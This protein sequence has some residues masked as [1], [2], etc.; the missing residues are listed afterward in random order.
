L[1]II[2]NFDVSYF[3]VFQV[4]FNVISKGDAVEDG[5]IPDSQVKDQ[6]DV[7]NE[8][9]KSSGFTFKLASI[10]RTTNEDW[11]NNAGPDTTQQTEMKEHLRQGGAGDLNVYTVG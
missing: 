11:F 5:N 4:Y 7:L 9:Y 1:S 10:H 6:I 8:A 2:S 3:N